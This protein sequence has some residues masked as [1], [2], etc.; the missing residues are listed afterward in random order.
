MGILNKLLDFMDSEESEKEEEKNKTLRNDNMQEQEDDSPIKLNEVADFV[1]ELAS[2]YTGDIFKER[3]EFINAN[4]SEDDIIF[5]KKRIAEDEVALDRISAIKDKVVEQERSCREIWGKSSYS[6]YDELESKKLKEIFKKSFEI[7]KKL[8]EVNVKEDLDEIIIKRLE[9][10]YKS[11]SLGETFVAPINTGLRIQHREV[12][13]ETYKF[14]RFKK[15]IYAEDTKTV[16]KEQVEKIKTIKIQADCADTQNVWIRCVTI[17]R[18]QLNFIKKTLVFENDWEVGEE[19]QLTYDI[20]QADEIEYYIQSILQLILQRKDYVLISILTPNH[21]LLD[22]LSGIISI[23]KE[24][25]KVIILNPEKYILME[26]NG[27]YK[28]M[29]FSFICKKDDLK[30][31]S[32]TLY[33]H[34]LRMF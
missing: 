5:L 12:N 18:Q 23:E 30:Q 22:Q 6:F 9:R 20:V 2:Y 7:I 24:R 14:G 13:Q 27:I 34:F 25:K 19:N 21:N 26:R 4:L 28:D 16:R 3:S 8:V 11:W 17:T 10:Y 1:R 15:D 29:S 33:D 32:F 31:M